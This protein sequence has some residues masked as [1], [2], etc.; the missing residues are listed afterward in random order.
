MPPPSLKLAKSLW[1]VPEADDPAQWDALFSRIKEEGFDGVEA[2]TLTWRKDKDLFTSLLQKHGL[3]LIC[4]IHT[5]GGDVDAKTGAYQYCRSNKLHDHLASFVKLTTE[6]KALGA[7]MINSHSGHDSWGSGDKA[8]SFFKYALKVEK[9]L[10]IPVVHE[11]HRHARP[12]ARRSRGASATARPALP[13]QR[14][15]GLARRAPPRRRQSHSRRAGAPPQAPPLLPAAQAA[16]A[17]LALPDRR[18]ALE[19]RARRPQ[20]QRRPVALVLRV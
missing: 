16:A 10:D 8:L 3:A 7:V 15:P 12:P 11:T 1:G 19:A 14:L 13:S 6:A 20:D 17:L 9:A 18:A 4:Q 5:T 2:I